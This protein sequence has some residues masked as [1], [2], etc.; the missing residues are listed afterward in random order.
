MKFSKFLIG[1][2]LAAASA[3]F[4]VSCSE[5]EPEKG[6]TSEGIKVEMTLPASVELT[7]GEACTLSMNSGS[8][9][10]TSDVV[11]LQD[12]N[13]KLIDCTISSV[14]SDSFTFVLPD[15]FV[16]GTYRI[17]IKRG[18]ERKLLG[19]LIIKIVTDKWEIENGTTVYGT[20]T[21]AEGPVA[22]VVISDGVDFA[23][24]NELGRYEL[25]SKKALG[26]VFMSVPSGYEPKTSGILPI[27]YFALNAAG[28]VPENVNFSLVK[29]NQS[30]YRVLF[31]GDMHLANRTDD[32]KQ[33]ANFA[34]DVNTNGKSGK[35]YAITLGD[36]TWDI[37]W[38]DNNFQFAQYLDLMN[39]SFSNL[40]V[41]HT[42]GNHDNDYKATNNFS[43]KNPF[44][45]SIA[46]NYYSFNIGEVHYVVLD[47]IDCSSY[48]GTTSRN[49]T[50]KIFVPQLQW[51][52][53]D[54]SY[55][56]KSTPVVLMMHA[57][58][59]Y[60]NGASSFR[61]NLSNVTELL[62]I[63]K[64]YKVHIVTGHTHK[65]FNVTAEHSVLKNYPD[66][67]EHNVTAVCG[68]W[69][70]SGKCT[71]GALMAPDGSPAGYAIWDVSGKNFNWI[72][73]GTGL[74]QNI[75]FRTYDLNNVSF[76]L[77]D[78]PGIG[79][80][81][82]TSFAKY[83]A[84]YPASKDNKVLINV[85]NYDPEWTI[86]VTTESGET[87]TPKAVQAYDP[88]HIKAMSVKR[89]TSTK[90]TT[91]NFVTQNFCHFFEVTAPNADTDL[92]ITVKDR[93]GRTFTEKM[94]RPK[95][96]EISSY[97]W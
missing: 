55:V 73:K 43:A 18:S 17:Y 79:G 3:L 2:T 88:L 94:E 78:V 65:N 49:Y 50:E 21:S 30:N 44:I 74:D 12:S 87:L 42:I 63:I 67:M 4:A 6:Q 20:V 76:S 36:M 69:W 84:A 93:F 57:P 61:N 85:W 81:A 29:A 25:K 45:L 1:L 52:A 8:V 56:D 59:F 16:E 54:L 66:I 91:P 40:T 89:Y 62:P 72:Y 46:P 24:S 39:R 83:C 82:A 68:D 14:T 10:Y 75:Q 92:T 47:D 19:S 96:F 34:N 31:F 11:Q 80:E 13:G 90:T 7:K 23:V 77:S 41:Y 53:K 97:T 22:G 15:S 26:Y 5:D 33:F 32:V 27:N 48:D 70:W 35:T 64:D 60:P 58:A 9:V 95:A 28:T 71:P 38:Y 86:T 37:Y 51:L